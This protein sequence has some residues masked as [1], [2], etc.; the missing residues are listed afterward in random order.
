MIPLVLLCL[1]FFSSRRRH[2]RCALVTGVQTCALP[3]FSTFKTASA[4]WAAPGLARLNAHLDP[5]DWHGR[6]D[7]TAG[8][9]ACLETALDLL[10]G[11]RMGRLPAQPLGLL[12]HHLR[13]DSAGW[14]FLAAFLARTAQHP[15]VRWIDAAAAL[16]IGKSPAAVM[17]RS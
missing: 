13:H 5:V 10:A 17:P 4:Y 7:A 3:I 14:D 1:F 11:L 12:S 2:T 6:G 9:T 15:V 8:A 16:E